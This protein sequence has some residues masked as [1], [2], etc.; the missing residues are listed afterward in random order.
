M[1]KVILRDLLDHLSN[2]T[3]LLKQ[4]KLKKEIKELFIELAEKVEML[5]MENNQLKTEVMSLY[6]SQ[7]MVFIV[8]NE[9]EGIL[10]V[11]DNYQTAEWERNL[12][13]MNGY[14][15]IEIKDCSVVRYEED[16]YDAQMNEAVH[17]RFPL[18]KQFAKAV[19]E[20]KVMK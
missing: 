8:V 20:V 10:S 18:L 2:E 11:C 4:A 12:F 5:K 14:K 19:S 6:N 9:K 16:F 17:K 15:G 1:E 7:S 3:K 13:E